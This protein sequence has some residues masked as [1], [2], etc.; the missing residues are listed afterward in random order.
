MPPR[1]TQASHCQVTGST[2]EAEGQ[3]HSLWCRILVRGK[4][5]K[6]SW[7]QVRKLTVDWPLDDTGLLF[8]FLDSSSDGTGEENKEHCEAKCPSSHNF[9]QKA[10]KQAVR[11]WQPWWHNPR[12]QQKQQQ[13][14][15]SETSQNNFEKTNTSVFNWD[16]A[17][18]WGTVMDTSEFMELKV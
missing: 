12:I 5:P 2:L 14:C 15:R 11:S 7:G 1:A 4:H 10:C 6:T 16:Y 18:P 3:I 9:L 8:Y 17:S 13:L